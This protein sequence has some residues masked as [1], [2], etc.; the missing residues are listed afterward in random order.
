MDVV[1]VTGITLAKFIRKEYTELP[2]NESICC[3]V[4]ISGYPHL[5]EPIID[6]TYPK[7]AAAHVWEDRSVYITSRGID[8]WEAR[9]RVNRT[10]ENSTIPQTYQFRTDIGKNYAKEKRVQAG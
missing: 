4:K 8:F 10:I 6:I 5:P 1:C 7:K 3:S 9:R 2:I